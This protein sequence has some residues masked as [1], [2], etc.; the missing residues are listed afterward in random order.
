MDCE[1][2][3]QILAA[4]QTCIR[5]EYGTRIET[6]CLYPSATQ[7]AVHVSEW[8]DGF[9]VSDAGG[10]ADCASFHGRDDYAISVGLKQASARFSLAVEGDHLFAFVPAKEWLP[11]A[12]M[13]VANG[14]A[15]AAT[16]AVETVVKAHEQSLKNKIQKVLESSVPE[17]LIA[18]GFDYIGK[19]GK[20]WVV[21]YAITVPNKPVLI[22]AVTPHHNSVAST[23]TTFGDVGRDENLRFAVFK[24]RPQ[25]EDAA[26]LRQVSDL[27]PLS[28]L[29]ENA[30]AL[31]GA[32][33]H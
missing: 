4:R 1:T 28:A 11:A 7:V 3:A 25:D 20:H 33:F 18:R 12:I 13:A 23:Y 19:S 21:D 9:R 22:K 15:H 26:L 5:S 14:A 31:I 6:Q 32:K 24:R 16:V 8:K 17:R 27:V 10:A 2:L 30:S 29:S